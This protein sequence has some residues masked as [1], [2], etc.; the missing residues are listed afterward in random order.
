MGVTGRTLTSE[1]FDRYFLPEIEWY[2]A[3]EKPDG[4]FEC[5]D[6]IWKSKSE[7]YNTDKEVHA[8]PKE[9]IDYISAK[10]CSG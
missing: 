4:W 5:E 10:E 3:F 1:W 8:L 9:I 7:M 6:Y 2:G